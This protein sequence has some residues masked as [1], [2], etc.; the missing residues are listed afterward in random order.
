LN[1]GGR[2]LALSYSLAQ[3]DHVF[4]VGFLVGAL[5]RLTL[6][7]QA[8]WYRRETWLGPLSRRQVSS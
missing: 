4:T 2:L 7:L 6:L 3:H 5:L 8:V 1:L